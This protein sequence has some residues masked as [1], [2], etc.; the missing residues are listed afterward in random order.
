[1]FRSTILKR[2]IPLAA[3]AMMAFLPVWTVGAEQDTGPS[4]APSLT[5]ASVAGKINYQG[6]LTDAAGSPYNGAYEMRFFLVDQE[7]G[8]TT[9]WDSGIL[10]VPVSDGLFSV[11]LE[12]GPD[13]I[14]GQALWLRVRVE[15][16][17]LSPRR[18]IVPT[19]YAMSLRP[20][21]QISGEPL[22]SSGAV[23]D[24]GL[25][26]FWPSA[27]ALGVSAAA[28][29]TALHGSALG[30]V[31]VYGYSEDNS[32]VRGHSQD[33]W[34]GYFTSDD[35]YGIR[36]NTDGDH[37]YDYGA[38]I[39]SNWGYGVYVESVHNQAVRGE[40]GDLS[41]GKSMPGGAW[42]SV[43]IGQS[44]GTW[45]SSWDNWGVYGDSHNYRGVQGNTD[46]TDRDYG[47]HTYDNIYSLNYHTLGAIMQV[48][49]N[50]GTEPIEPGEVVV[51]SGMTKGI[52]PDAPPIPRVSRAEAA[53]NP[54]V[55]GVVYSRYNIDAADPSKDDPTDPSSRGDM[56]V[57]PP[58]SVQPGE[59]MLLVVQG[60]AKVKIARSDG[61]IQP[62]DLLATGGVGGGADKAAL[63]SIGGVEIPVPGTVFGKALEA[64]DPDKDTTHVFV[65]L[66]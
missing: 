21:A 25:T 5:T 35:G 45:G 57:A 44:G 15:G 20:G 8:G 50:G 51:F 52:E 29:G 36:V 4:G 13:V 40:A 47:L 46:R 26:G 30:G 61:G 41:A 62:G 6:R 19:A 12:V 27:K 16:V 17:N 58:G 34:G 28:T 14:D 31:G 49:Q 48:V 60:P 33:S 38:Y 55:A 18:E 54:A 32:A 1:M 53:N 64:S 43:G 39:T 59:Y 65:T 11:N 10:D 63:V 56:E 2:W 7:T 42:G 22:V 37:I 9:L 24:V 3:L 23:V 66:Q